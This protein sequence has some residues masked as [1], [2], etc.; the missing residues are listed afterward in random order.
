MSTIQIRNRRASYEYEFIETYI[1]GICLKGTEIKSLRQGKAALSD[2]YCVFFKGELY[3]KGVHISEYEKAT[4]YNHDPR[5]DRKL[6]LNKKELKKWERKIKERGLTIVPVTLF[7]NDRGYAKLKI[8]LARGKKV[9]DKR[10]SI[11]EKDMKRENDRF[12]KIL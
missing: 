4:H 3:A 7:I 6:L 10:D 2:S 11:K 5:S 9:Y 12:H 8:A 1:A